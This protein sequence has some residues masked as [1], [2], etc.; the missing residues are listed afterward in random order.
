[1]GRSVVRPLRTG[2][3]CSA[4]A[5]CGRPAGTGGERSAAGERGEARRR[6]AVRPGTARTTATQAHRGPRPDPPRVQ[7]EAAGLLPARSA[8]EGSAQR[9]RSG[10]LAFAPGAA[11]RARGRVVPLTW[12]LSLVALSDNVSEGG[13]DCCFH[14]KQQRPRRGHEHALVVPG[15]AVRF[16]PDA[17]LSAQRG[18]GCGRP[19]H[20]RL[21]WGSILLG[22]LEHGRG[23]LATPA[24]AWTAATEFSC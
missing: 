11:Q 24:C 15:V 20:A 5:E 2:S 1:M 9:D 21:R 19:G 8:G 13:A 7:G 6:R 22:A 16:S 12:W 10:Y 14:R 4:L 3:D 18:N 17:P 23:W